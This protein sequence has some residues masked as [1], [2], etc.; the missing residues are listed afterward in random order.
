MG[1]GSNTPNLLDPC[2]QLD[3]GGREVE[4]TGTG[5]SGERPV[6]DPPTTR[7][8]YSYGWRTG[9]G[10]SGTPVGRQRSVVD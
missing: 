6:R 4:V 8:Y 2:V 10:V 7:L 5:L 3:K 9:I 1:L